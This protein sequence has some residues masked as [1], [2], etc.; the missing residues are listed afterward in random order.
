MSKGL[1]KT[2]LNTCM[3]IGRSVALM[4]TIFPKNLL[5]SSEGLSHHCRDRV[6]GD[7]EMD[8]EKICSGNSW[9]LEV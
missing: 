4:K 7:E 8:D 9:L 1:G 5:F 3:E 6:C 2:Y